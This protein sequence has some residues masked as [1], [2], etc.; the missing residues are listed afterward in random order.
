MEDNGGNEVIVLWQD[1]HEVSGQANDVNSQVVIDQI[2]Y[3]TGDADNDYYDITP[4]RFRGRQPTG[5]PRPSV[6]TLRR[7]LTDAIERRQTMPVP[8]P[9]GTKNMVS[10]PCIL[11][12]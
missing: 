10:K 12:I 1:P 3:Q 9:R 6:M 2:D 5:T 7:D 4:P 11:S 8:R